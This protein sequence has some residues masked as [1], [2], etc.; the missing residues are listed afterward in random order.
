MRLIPDFPLWLGHAGDLRDLRAILSAGIQA[1]VELAAEEPVPMLTRDLV[2]Y[3]FPIVDGEANPDWLL[4]AAIEAVTGMVAAG[5]ST[6]V[7]CGA[8]MSRSPVITAA[9]LSR[10]SG[11]RLETVLE[12]LLQGGP[13][14]VSPNLLAD[15]Q[16]LLA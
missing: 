14:D 12:R 3:R 10:H 1:V 13:S 7:T 11:E 2:S 4:R 9:A 5:V 16:R 15:V 8:G 6:L